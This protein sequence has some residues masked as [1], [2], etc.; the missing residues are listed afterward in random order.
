MEVGLCDLRRFSH[1]GKFF[2][3]DEH[4]MHNIMSQ[5]QF[6]TIFA[7]SLQA[8]VIFCI[9]VTDK[10]AAF[11]KTISESAAELEEAANRNI[12][13]REKTA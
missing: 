2:V 3:I 5:R 10:P 8:N 9:F 11:T 4:F 7:L 1:C 6:R 12:S 13:L